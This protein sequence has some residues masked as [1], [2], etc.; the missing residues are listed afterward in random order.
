MNNM[1]TQN[2]K[3]FVFDTRSLMGEAAANDIITRMIELLEI[4]SEIRMIFAAAPSQ[5][6]VLE[7][8][9]KS[10]DVDWGSVVA[11]HMDE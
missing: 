1:A 2:L 11:F 4:K 8:L 9:V 10:K 3:T 6:E 7:H 5:N